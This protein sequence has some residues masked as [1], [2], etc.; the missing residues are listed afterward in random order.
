[1]GMAG[2]PAFLAL[3]YALTGH[4][5][6]AARLWVMLAQV[7]VD[8]VTCLLT[9]GLAALLL[10]IAY[11]RARPQRVFIA[12]L[13]LAPLCPFTANYAAVP[14]TEVLATFFTTPALF[15]LCLLVTP[16]HNRGLRRLP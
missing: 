13:W 12:A 7:F 8:L 9:A 1:M 10:L 6:E 16:A 11:D 15:P 2:Y 14:L 3:I 5:G 4:T